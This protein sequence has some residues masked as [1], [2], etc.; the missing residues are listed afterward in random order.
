MNP[1]LS[2]VNEKLLY[3]RL[4][5]GLLG[6]CRQ[7][8]LARALCQSIVAQ[9]VLAYRC[10]LK[11]IAGNYHARRPEAVTTVA[12]L[13]A[14]LESVD[15]HPAEAS[16][17]QDLEARQSSWLAELLRAWSGIEGET[18]PAT[19]V[20]GDEAMNLIPLQP[21]DP[22]A[23]TIPLTEVS[24]RNWLALLDEL[25]QRHRETMFEC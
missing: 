13:V 16:E 11:E 21:V 4:L 19:S 8:H 18:P 9:L 1:Y 10:H 17:L 6:D 25:V 7:V 22:L 15:K 24:V 2:A 14:A 23:K 12:L 5:S 20:S 3:A